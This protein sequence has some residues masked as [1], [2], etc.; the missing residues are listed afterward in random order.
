MDPAPPQ[1]Y[2]EGI[3]TQGHEDFTRSDGNGVQ[4]TGL[5]NEDAR[6]EVQAEDQLLA[7]TAFEEM[8]LDPRF[9]QALYFHYESLTFV[10]TSKWDSIAHP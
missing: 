8:G 5:V 6:L 2:T 10:D 1:Y 3:N 7:K 4:Q 9:V